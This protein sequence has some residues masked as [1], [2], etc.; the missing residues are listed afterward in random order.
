MAQ[1]TGLTETALTA[2]RIWSADTAET[3]ASVLIRSASAA[4]PYRWISSARIQ[5]MAPQ[6]NGSHDSRSV[7]IPSRFPGGQCRSLHDLRQ[8]H[9][10][11]VFADHFLRIE[12]DSHEILRIVL[13]NEAIGPFRR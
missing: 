9:P 8:T 4:L 11:L 5:S 10:C 2:I 1:S 7:H 12:N 13:R 6:V 3:S